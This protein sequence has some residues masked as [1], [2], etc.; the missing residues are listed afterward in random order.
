MGMMV[1]D[2]LVMARIT[3]GMPGPK[4]ALTLGVPT[5]NFTEQQ[6]RKALQSNPDAV[7]ISTDFLKHFSDHHGF[8]ANLGFE[9]VHSSDISDYEG[10]DIIGDLNDPSFA[11][12]VPG[13][14]DLV[15][16]HGTIEHIF[17]APTA[18][19]TIN[20]LTRKGGV[21]V[22]SAPAN[23]FMDHGFWQLSPDLLR[24]FYQSAGFE[25]LTCALLVL[26][27]RPFAVPVK[28]NYYR[29]HGRE[30]V[31]QHFPEALLV[32]AARKTQEVTEVRVGL[33]DYYAQ[34]HGGR[35]NYGTEIFF[36]PF[37]SATLGRLWRVRTVAIVLGLPGAL[38][39]LAIKAKRRMFGRSGRSK[40]KPG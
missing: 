21:V 30:F 18:L 1:Y 38:L 8:F 37:G 29:S 14:F 2:A 33:Q 20:R 27:P 36:I 4:T 7:G 25:V 35:S 12:R 17:D 34:M 5:L 6:F 28:Q 19:R 24:S 23:G 15:Y 11:D 32:F 26:G 31:A 9:R 40:G 39:E 3:R 16:D 22:H 13:Q 10:A